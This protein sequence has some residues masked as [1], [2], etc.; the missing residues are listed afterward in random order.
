MKFIF[1]VLVFFISLNITAQNTYYTPKN[2][3]TN[4]KG[5]IRITSNSQD[6][7]QDTI[8][9]Q[10]YDEI[11]EYKNYF[12]LVD[13]IIYN[14]KS[15]YF[16]G[17]TLIDSTLKKIKSFDEV[18]EITEGFIIENKN[19]LLN[20]YSIQQ[21][22]Y[23]CENGTNIELYLK[24]DVLNKFIV[25][26]S[27]YVS[28]VLNTVGTQI[29]KI[30]EY[31]Y[32][33]IDF[34][35]K[36][37]QIC[38]KDYALYTFYGQL[39]E[40]NIKS[41]YSYKRDKES[42]YITCKL[43][44]GHQTLISN[45]KVYFSDYD[46]IFK[47]TITNENRFIYQKGKYYFVIDSLGNQINKK[48]IQNM[49][50]ISANS[51]TYVNW[52]KQNDMYF[53]V[54][55]NL[56]PINQDKYYYLEE[57][58]DFWCYKIKKNR[59]DEGYFAYNSFGKPYMD[60]MVNN[61]YLIGNYDYALVIQKDEKYA[62][63]FSADQISQFIY[64]SKPQVL[65]SYN[66]IYLKAKNKNNE[67]VLIDGFSY[68]TGG[69]FQNLGLTDIIIGTDEWAQE[70]DMFLLYKQD[71]FC[72]IKDYY[73]SIKDSTELTFEYQ[74][75]KIDEEF[76]Y[77][78]NALMVSKNGKWGMYGNGL[79]IEYKY[80]NIE[81]D[82]YILDMTNCISVYANNKKGLIK[83]L[84]NEKII[85]VL[86]P[87]YDEIEID[88]E[89][90]ILKLNNKY[91]VKS[92]S[93]NTAD[94][95][96]SEFIFTDKPSSDF[97]YGS[98]IEYSVKGEVNGLKC[99]CY[100]QENRKYSMRYN[101]LCYEK[102][103][104]LEGT[105][106]LYLYQEGNLYGLISGYAFDTLLI[107]IYDEIKM[108]PNE[109]YI[110]TSIDGKKGVRNQRGK[111][112]IAEKYDE[113]I[114]DTEYYTEF[115]LASLDNIWGLFDGNKQ[116]LKI[117]FDDIVLSDEYIFVNKAGKWGMYDYQLKLIKELKFN[118][119]KEIKEELMRE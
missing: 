7:K 94:T 36:K 16:K 65:Q 11:Y 30:N 59:E 118:S 104:L 8:I 45:D 32:I 1:T 93:D 38:K 24:E 66:D 44:N 105:D 53:F 83:I 84:N 15:R 107:A 85:T 91:A 43:K 97:L 117:E 37:I 102:I 98:G 95:I 22:K 35:N 74:D 25:F 57:L 116:K 54:D 73:R 77:D 89:F 3:K 4:K 47:T 113:L 29:I 61:V 112:I 62:I 40:K 39:L 106:G 82:P 81:Y 92:V 75:Y 64:Y 70:R 60:T 34:K 108:H 26:Q 9:R 52:I 31:K 13:T 79:N 88:D 67:Q 101:Y 115:V 49:G 99:D 46:V 72:F 87:V 14:K 48:P 23:L 90:F 56:K 2:Y 28:Q 78:D 109:D 55:N 110:L 119:I 50:L 19:N 33:T 71:K 76:M 18:N 103:T 96:K 5:V 51:S 10:I 27:K 20:L 58:P 100:V 6:S 21:S 111:V 12:I 69:V 63:S 68:K 42:K 17:V 86:E 41:H 114:P 80:D